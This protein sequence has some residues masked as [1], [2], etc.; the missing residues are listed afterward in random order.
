MWT[1]NNRLQLKSGQA[2]DPSIRP[3]LIDRQIPRL[4][5]RLD[6]LNQVG[7]SL[8]NEQKQEFTQVSSRL[9]LLKHRRELLLGRTGD[10]YVIA[11]PAP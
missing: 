7:S 6:Q 9:D 8:S 10:D 4:Q 1:E 5:A 11:P 3:V 2:E